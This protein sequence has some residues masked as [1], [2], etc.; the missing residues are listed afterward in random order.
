MA[1]PA[2]CTCSGRSN[3]VMDSV[4]RG[5][6]IVAVRRDVHAEGIRQ[7]LEAVQNMPALI[8]T[9]FQTVGEK[10]WDGFAALRVEK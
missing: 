2:C 10:G 5:G 8:S 3:S 9:A 6:A 1:K 7:S 4:V